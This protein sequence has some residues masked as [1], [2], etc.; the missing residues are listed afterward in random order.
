[1]KFLFLLLAP[2][3]SFAIVTSPMSNNFDNTGAVSRS[4]VVDIRVKFTAATA[5]GELQ[6]W[7]LTADDGATVNSSDGES[8]GLG[9]PAA[10]F[11][12]KTQS[13]GAQGYCRVFGKIVSK[14]SGFGDNA[15]AGAAIYL[16]ADQL[17]GKVTGIT[18][19]AASDHKV[20]T[21][22][23]A[24]SATGDLEVFVNLL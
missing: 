11:A 5:A 22:L 21:A 15:V 13:A 14:H 17:G 16:S 9:D 1:M 2:V 4:D 23:D 8:A 19:P 6:V 7:D 12:V 3:L 10:C 18:A 24:S 20:A